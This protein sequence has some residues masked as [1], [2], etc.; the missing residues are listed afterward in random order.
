MCDID[1]FK[2]YNDSYG[3]QQGDEALVKVAAA[4][5]SQC[6]RE[7][8]LAARYGGGRICRHFTGN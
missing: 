8:D 5:K 7:G 3:H 2:N 6:R 4:L 1:F